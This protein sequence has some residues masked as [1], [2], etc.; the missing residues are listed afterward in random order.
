MTMTFKL[1]IECDNAAFNPR[2]SDN[3]P[4]DATVEVAS[5]LR[6]CAEHLD[7]GRTNGALYDTNGNRVGSY[8]FYE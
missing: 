7:N 8:S 1:S 5:I 2:D 3:E 6:H 4:E